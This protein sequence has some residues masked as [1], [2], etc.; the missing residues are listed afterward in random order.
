MCSWIHL[1][2]YLWIPALAQLSDMSRPCSDGPTISTHCFCLSACAHSHQG[3]TQ[4]V[5]CKEALTV[6]C[7]LWTCT[8]GAGPPEILCPKHLACLS[9]VPA[10]YLPA[11]GLKVDGPL[12]L[13][14]S[15]PHADPFTRLG[16]NT[17]SSSIYLTEYVKHLLPYKEEIWIPWFSKS[18]SCPQGRGVQSSLKSQ[19]KQDL[20][21][22][23]TLWSLLV[24]VTWRHSA[25]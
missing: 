15:S 8:S 21:S 9:P 7:W 5:E 18:Q 3:G 13:P 19:E 2:L 12:E 25:R 23:Q 14:W 11:E 6:G 10:P 16:S 22:N 24:A 17:A 4:R 1:S 20:H